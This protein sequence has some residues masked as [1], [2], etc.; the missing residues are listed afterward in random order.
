MLIGVFTAGIGIFLD[1]AIDQL[2]EIKYETLK[3]CILHVQRTTFNCFFFFLILI[4]E[5]ILPLVQ[6]L[7][8]SLDVDRCVENDCLYLPY[9]V[10]VAFNVF[11]VLISSLLVTYIEV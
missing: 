1:V 7:T 6:S 10:W 11:F 2:S 3:H 4:C 5:G 9:L 8:L